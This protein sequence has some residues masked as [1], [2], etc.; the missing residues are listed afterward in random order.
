[1]LSTQNLRVPAGTRP[2][3]IKQS[4]TINIVLK[5]SV[6][7]KSKNNQRVPQMRCL[8]NLVMYVQKKAHYNERR[9]TSGAL[10]SAYNQM[11]ILPPTET[12]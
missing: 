4:T 8:E 12:S 7:V 3:D 10:N 1:M 2:R 11:T 5:I 9:E 6:A